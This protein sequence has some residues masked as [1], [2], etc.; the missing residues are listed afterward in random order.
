MQKQ[1]LP[2]VTT[3]REATQEKERKEKLLREHGKW[4]SNELGV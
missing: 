3:A 4:Y 1:S 2:T